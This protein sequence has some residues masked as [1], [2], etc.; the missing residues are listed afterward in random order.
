MIDQEVVL[1]L[2]SFLTEKTI[3]SSS[4]SLDLVFVWLLLIAKFYLP[5]SRL[6]CPYILSSIICIE[7]LR[8]SGFL[9][10]IF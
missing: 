5:Y 4:D 1:I 6:I 9:L 7:F 2:N 10:I 3:L 8:S